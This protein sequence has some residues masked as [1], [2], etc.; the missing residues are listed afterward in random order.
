MVVQLKKLIKTCLSCHQSQFI[1]NDVSILSWLTCFFYCSSSVLNVLKNCC[2]LFSHGILFL[3]LNLRAIYILITFF[4]PSWPLD[5]CRRAEWGDDCPFN[6]FVCQP[7]LSLRTGVGWVCESE[8]NPP[9]SELLNCDKGKPVPLVI[10]LFS[11][12]TRDPCASWCH[13]KLA[14][15]SLA[16]F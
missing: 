11:A 10:R 8:W 1:Y 4:S 3:C 5:P 6:R 7:A 13:E 15:S 14:A 2:R 12:Q 16:L 9:S